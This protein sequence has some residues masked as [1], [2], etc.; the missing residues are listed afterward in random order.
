M[1]HW[2]FDLDGT[3]V[4][5]HQ[6][7]FDTLK[8][9]LAS[10]GADMTAEDQKEMLRI[11][12]KDRPQFFARKVGQQN[13]QAA[14]DKLFVETAQDYLV[15]ETFEGVKDLLQTLKNRE[16]QIAIWTAR[17]KASTWPLLK[18]SGLDQYISFLVTSTCI[19]NCKPHPEGLHKV[20]EHFGCSPQDLHM[21]GDHDND[22]QAAKAAG[23]KAIRGY[24][25]DASLEAN[26]ALADHKFTKVQDLIRWLN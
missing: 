16:A 20:A 26:C 14:A 9:V 8:K 24:W 3:L 25:H 11:S 22:M 5:S 18:H 4:N 1:K 21:V 15:T 13:A 2:V 17:D 19:S 7:Y 12:G 6:P 10:Y 23:A